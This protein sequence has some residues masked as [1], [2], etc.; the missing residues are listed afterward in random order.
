VRGPLHRRGGDPLGIA[1]GM[2]EQLT[3]EPGLLSGCTRRGGGDAQVVTRP[4]REARRARVRFEAPTLS[5]R[6]DA[7]AGMDLHVAQIAR[8]AARAFVQLAGENQPRSH[9]TSHEHH[10]EIVDVAGR[11]GRAL[12]PRRGCQVGRER[13]QQLRRARLQQL[14]QRHIFPAEAGRGRDDAGPLLDLS[15]DTDPERVRFAERQPCRSARGFCGA[16]DCLGDL[17]RF[18]RESAMPLLSENAARGVDHRGPHV[19]AAQVDADS[20]VVARSH[21]ARKLIR[22]SARFAPRRPFLR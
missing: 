4:R 12:A 2:L 13:H 6:A 5:A 16:N 10:E 7:A 14:L 1:S 22:P 18:L 19:A 8:G 21:G 17:R 15:S 3:A 20:H 9:R 11:A